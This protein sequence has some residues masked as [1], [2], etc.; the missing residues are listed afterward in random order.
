MRMTSVLASGALCAVL[1][2]T[3]PAIAAGFASADDIDRA[4]AQ[5]TGASIGAEGG[6][7]L[8]VDRRL[9]LAQCDA[10]LALEWYGRSRDTVLVRCPVTGGWRLFVPV[11]APQVASAVRREPVVS[12]GEAVA[13]IVRGKGFTLSRQGEAMEQGAIGE[14]IRV[15]PAGQR[16]ESMRVRV[17]EPGKV[18][19]DL[20]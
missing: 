6:A 20:P 16:T 3:T 11:E 9:R 5:F 8:P 7:R 18:G 4:V 17:I 2:A 13:I 12:R 15:R 19:M 14:W 1:V 10:P